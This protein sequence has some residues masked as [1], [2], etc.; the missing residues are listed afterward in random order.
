MN[1]LF[2]FLLRQ[3]LQ[4]MALLFRCSD[5]GAY[6]VLLS[7]PATRNDPERGI[8]LCPQESNA[9][10]KFQTGV[11]VINN[12]EVRLEFAHLVC[13]GGEVSVH[14]KPA[15]PPFGSDK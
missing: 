13:N 14:N 6:G 12:Q 4:S 10:D 11:R 5:S 2:D 15:S 3:T 9:A 8:Y 7:R 1:D